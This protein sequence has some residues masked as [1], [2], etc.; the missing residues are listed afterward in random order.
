[1]SIIEAFQTEQGRNQLT[2]EI[3]NFMFD[4]LNVPLP[5]NQQERFQYPKCPFCKGRPRLIMVKGAELYVLVRSGS[6]VRLEIPRYRVETCCSGTY[7]TKNEGLSMRQLRQLHDQV[8]AA[9][10]ARS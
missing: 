4:L 1:M 8:E 6:P 10:K 9:K 2:Q 5:E 3:S 7:K